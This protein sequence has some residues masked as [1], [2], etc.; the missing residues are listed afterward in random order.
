MN[1]ICF[2]D[3]IKVMGM[4]S[5]NSIDMLLTDIPYGGVNRKSNGLRNLNKKDADTFTMDMQQLVREMVRVTKGSGYI[6][7]GWE[8]LS[9]I[10][11]IIRELKFSN[12][13]IVWK[14]TNPSICHEKT[15]EKPNL[16]GTAGQVLHVRKGWIDPPTNEILNTDGKGSIQWQ[17]DWEEEFKETLLARSGGA[18]FEAVDYE[19]IVSD[20]KFFIKTL[21]SFQ[22]QKIIEVCERKKID[23]LGSFA[24]QGADI[25]K[26]YIKEE[27][28][29]QESYNQALSDIISAIKEF[30]V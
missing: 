19:M 17:E 25:P 11:S 2:E 12:R 1:E 4:M 8:Q 15:N 5:S 16:T 24:Y 20:M 7:C 26:K 13:V 28:P 6:F 29:K 23:I 30:K 18:C 27:L 14:K 9:E 3:C 22:K 10:V 21:L